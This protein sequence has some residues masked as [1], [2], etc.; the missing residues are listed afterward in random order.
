MARSNP[1]P[2]GKPRDPLV[3]YYSYRNMLPTLQI[4][5]FQAM[6]AA[7]APFHLILK[8]RTYWCPMT[9]WKSRSAGVRTRVKLSAAP[10]FKNDIYFPK[11]PYSLTLVG[12]EANCVCMRW[13]A[14][15]N[16]PA[17]QIAS[18]GQK[19][20]KCLVYGRQYFQQCLWDDTVQTDENIP[21]TSE[22]ST[23]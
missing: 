23:V 11:S 21:W 18:T 14:F 16:V 12:F 6:L 4:C 5:I 17:S 1:C 19:T 13:Q 9:V 7:C 22:T 3:K 15:K 2:W 8:A 10:S 20:P